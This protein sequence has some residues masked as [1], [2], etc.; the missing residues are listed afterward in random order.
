M[1]TNDPLVLSASQISLFK[2]CKRAWYKRYI[3]K[4]KE[5]PKPWLIYGVNFHDCIEKIYR[6]ILGEEVQQKEYDQEIIDLVNEGFRKEV[7]YVPNKFIPEKEIKFKINEHASM[8]GYVDLIDVSNGKI[9]DHKTIKGLSYALTEEDL[10]QDLQLNIY[11]YWYL[12]T[13]KEKDHVYYRHNQLHK[14]T[15]EHSKFTEVVVSR[16]YVETYWE[17]QVLPYVNEIVDLRSR[18]DLKEYT[19]NTNACDD[20]GGCFHKPDCHEKGYK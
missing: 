3:E 10:K 1:Q 8:R 12:Q 20:Y 13:L 5:P 17:T 2:R 4:I 9:V 7:L 16:K 18:L 11:G 14:F 19:C 15:P 6:K